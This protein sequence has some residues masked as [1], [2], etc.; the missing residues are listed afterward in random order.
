MQYDVVASEARLVVERA[1]L[2]EEI[3]RLEGLLFERNDL[4]R[5]TV[6][7]YTE[8]VAQLT[9]ERDAARDALQRL[10]DKWGTSADV[11]HH[12]VLAMDRLFQEGQS[13]SG[14]RGRC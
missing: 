9:Q 1:E 11:I 4:M 8:Q 14:I 3:A 5:R 2:K 10:K 12:E 7:H 13:D 6:E